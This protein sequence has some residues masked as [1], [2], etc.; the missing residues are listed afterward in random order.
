MRIHVVGVCG[1]GM[2]SLA[3][4]LVE[5]GHE[6]S[7]SDVAFDPP[8]GP[9]L[10]EWGIRLHRG[11]DPENLADRPDLVVIGNV[12]KKDNPEARAAID[13]GLRY[14]HIAG[15][16][17]E[18]ALSGTRPLVVGGTH[19]KTTT[20]ALSAWLLHAL[21]RDPG[22]LIGGVPRNFERS[23]RAARR[24]KLSGP[25]NGAL[26][27][28]LPFVVEGDE[29]D[30][31][32]FEKTAKFLHYGA[33][34]GIVTS[35]EHDHVDIYPTAESYLEAFRRFVREIPASGLVV[36]N[37]ADPAVVS[38]VR[39]E[40]RADV[41]YYALEGEATNGV[42]PRWVGA[43]S[44]TDVKGTT[45]DLYAGG[46]ACGRLL[47]PLAGRYNLSNALAAIAAVVEGFGV[48]VHELARPLAAFGGVRRRQEI[49][50]EPNG[51][52]VVDDFAHHPTAVR[53]TLAALR[54]RFPSG[55]LFAVFEPRSATA[56]RAMHQE[57]YARSFDDADVILFPPLGREGLPPAE[58]LDLGRLADDLRRA[59]K[60]ARALSS[61]DPILEELG[62][63]A[64]SGDTIAILSNGAFGGIHRRLLEALAGERG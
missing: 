2:G 51:I 39:R 20:T 43:P 60:D 38:V 6:V 40:A 58:R 52:V 32:F 47:V 18:F 16:L 21:G 28:R 7:G 13:G 34:V 15:A 26:A 46:S 17:R 8:M 11:F 12:C 19:G 64:V 35:I 10:A 27:A 63:R 14:T 55:R 1:T 56:C 57:E 25:E 61:I 9:A 31:A 22:F 33:E 3:G 41:S 50:G 24:R 49:I 29:Y 48:K 62:K 23:F 54:V 5:L 4:L 30:T 59:G 44:V 42:A 53:K 36:A 37:A 45:F